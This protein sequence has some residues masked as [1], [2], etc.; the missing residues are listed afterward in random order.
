MNFPVAQSNFALARPWMLHDSVASLV[1][2]MALIQAMLTEILSINTS[3]V[4]RGNLASL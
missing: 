2:W 4:W 1:K 3:P